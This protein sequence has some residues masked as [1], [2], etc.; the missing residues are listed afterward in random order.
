MGRL[1][2]YCE[3]APMSKRGISKCRAEA[4]KVGLY[5]SSE[6]FGVVVK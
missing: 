2:W 3:I 6:L 4:L 5:I 1:S